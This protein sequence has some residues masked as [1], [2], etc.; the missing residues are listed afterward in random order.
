MSLG[1]WQLPVFVASARAP[2]GNYLYVFV[3]RAHQG[4]V[5]IKPLDIDP[6]GFLTCS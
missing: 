2:T 1:I 3:T 4:F 5:N 6:S